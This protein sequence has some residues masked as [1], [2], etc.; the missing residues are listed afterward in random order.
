[1]ENRFDAWAFIIANIVLVLL[2]WFLAVA[3]A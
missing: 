2:V 3:V 1:M